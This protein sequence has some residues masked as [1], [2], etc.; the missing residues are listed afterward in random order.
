MN[1]III[2]NKIEEAIDCID[3]QVMGDGY[4]FN[5]IVVAITFENLSRVRRQQLIY[6]IFA[7]EIKS[8]ELHALSIK[9]LTPSEAAKV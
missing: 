2:K 3:V 9:T 1:E 6:D 8:G 4:H 7:E 5:V